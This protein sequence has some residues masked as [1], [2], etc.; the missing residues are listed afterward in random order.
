MYD[1]KSTKSMEEAQWRLIGKQATPRNLIWRD[2]QHFNKTT[3]P[4]HTAK[5]TQEGFPWPSQSPYLKLIEDLWRILRLRI[6]QRH[7]HNLFKKIWQ[8][9]RPEVEAQC[10]KKFITPYSRSLKAVLFSIR[11]TTKY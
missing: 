3:N 5:M 1:L 4:N 6:H 7:P 10:C 2:D 11:F 8:E 9:A